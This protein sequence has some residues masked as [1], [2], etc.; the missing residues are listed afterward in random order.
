MPG[1]DVLIVG[2]GI[3]GLT[4]AYHLKKNNPD[5]SIRI[6]DRSSTYAQGNTARS[7]A[8]FRNLFTLDINYKLSNSSIEF[9]RHVQEKM[10]FDLGMKFAGY[11]FLLTEDKPN[12]VSTIL[13]RGI[14]ELL[15]IDDVFEEGVLTAIPEAETSRIMGLGEVKNALYGKN[16][17]VMEPDLLSAF[18][19]EEL[20][21]MGVEFGFSTE[22]ERIK[23]DPVNPLNY[24]GEPFIW[25]DKVISGLETNKGTMTADSYILATDVWTTSLLDPIGVDSHVRPKKRQVFQVSG[26]EIRNIL[27][28][29][30]VNEAS[31]DGL[32]PFTILPKAGVYLRPAPKEKA[33]WVGAAD[34]VGRDFSLQE[35][36]PAE[37][38][39]YDLNV[40][41]VVEP[42]FR[43]F[44]SGK[45][46]GSWA[47][48]YSYNT[49][50]K[51]PYIF[52][53]LNMIIATG[54][55][56]SG[57]LKGDGIGRVVEATYSDREKVKLFDGSEMDTG[58]LGLEKSGME[59]EEVIL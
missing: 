3:V 58:S 9:Y 37:T 16:C 35:D 44:G 41:S 10:K 5:L 2:A 11:L 23:L 24:P 12:W 6:I 20:V 18:Y 55:S 56:G 7:A 39:F 54:T 29:C 8:G 52:K 34:D 14:A 4:S 40:R 53:F 22:V 21:K 42:Y 25:Q 46:T 15:D 43:A 49:I 48:Y 26:E 33:F 13:E 31:L 59:H 1:K 51:T 32:F 50:N 47:G 17:G 57:I 28:K 38:D 27:Y 19:Y 45:I 30:K 36:P